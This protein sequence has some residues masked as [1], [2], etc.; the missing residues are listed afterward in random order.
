MGKT[1]H[2][3]CMSYGF[4]ADTANQQK[5]LDQRKLLQKSIKSNPHL[6]QL[7]IRSYIA[8]FFSENKKCNVKKHASQKM[9]SG[10]IPNKYIEIWMLGNVQSER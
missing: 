9:F 1:T 8:L 4:A 3:L 6:L 2:F 7:A 10:L 5:S